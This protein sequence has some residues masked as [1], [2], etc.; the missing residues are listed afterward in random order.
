[1]KKT[2]LLAFALGLMGATSVLAQSPEQRIRS[3]LRAQG[4]S[5]IE[6]DRDDGK[7]EVEAKKGRHEYEMTYS[8][9]GRLL[10]RERELRDDDDD[11]RKGKKSGKKNGKKA[12]KK[13]DQ[14]NHKNKGRKGKGDRDDDDRRDRRDRDD[15]RD[16]HDRDDRDD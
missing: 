12:D 5:R 16:R 4:F 14:K 7:I 8:R 2:L 1:M 15:R 13:S 11:D 6:I 10:E 3:D 9:A